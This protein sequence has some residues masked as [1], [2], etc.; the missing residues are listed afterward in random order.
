MLLLNWSVVLS[1]VIADLA[2][3]SIYT[4]ENYVFACVRMCVYVRMTVRMHTCMLL[5]TNVPLV[6]Q[7]TADVYLCV[8]VL[9]VNVYVYVYACVC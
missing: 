5:L 4:I 3:K 7:L 6:C 2:C 9:Y 1:V 8:S